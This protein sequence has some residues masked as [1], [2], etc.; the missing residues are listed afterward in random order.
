MN[1]SPILPPVS[2]KTRI[3][4][5]FLMIIFVLSA[6]CALLGYYV[7]K[8]NIIDRA[9]RK[10]LTDLTAARMV[11]TAEIERLGQGLQLIDHLR[12]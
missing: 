6:S 7:T 3:L 11:Y 2:V 4:L 12:M 1:N 5:S 10:V 9:E 8:T